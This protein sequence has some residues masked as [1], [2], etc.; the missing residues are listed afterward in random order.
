MNVKPSTDIRHVR[1][2]SDDLRR[3]G[4]RQADRARTSVS[5]SLDLRRTTTGLP[6]SVARPSGCSV[7]RRRFSQITSAPDRPSRRPAQVRLGAIHQIHAVAELADVGAVFD[8]QLAQSSRPFVNATDCG[9]FLTGNVLADMCLEVGQDPLA[10]PVAATRTCPL[11]EQLPSRGQD[12]RDGGVDLF[13]P[14]PRPPAPRS[15]R[16]RVRPAE[17]GRNPPSRT[18]HSWWGG[19]RLPRAC[20]LVNRAPL[21]SSPFRTMRR[22]ARRLTTDRESPPWSPPRDR[23]V[24]AFGATS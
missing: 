8:A 20:R 18:E 7:M 21:D 2:T 9:Q 12:L 13:S 23:D 6:V 15:R 17:V 4:F 24:S 5:S 11:S 22:W 14:R 19:V 16:G 3:I 10:S 1:M